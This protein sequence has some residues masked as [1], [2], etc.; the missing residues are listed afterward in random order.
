V[1]GKLSH[2]LGFWEKIKIYMRKQKIHKILGFSF[3]LISVQIS[4]PADW[5]TRLNNWN[6]NSLDNVVVPDMKPDKLQQSSH[7]C[8]PVVFPFVELFSS[9]EFQHFQKGVKSKRR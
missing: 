8:H 5:L 6:K 7:V 3:A 2:P 1:G 9:L 4:D